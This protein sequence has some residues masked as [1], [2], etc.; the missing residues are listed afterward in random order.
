MHTIT[1]I[2]GAV[3]SVFCG[4]GRCWWGQMKERRGKT[5]AGR[6][7]RS[8][9][10]LGPR[11]PPSRATSAHLVRPLA[12]VEC[13]CVLALALCVHLGVLHAKP[14]ARDRDADGLPLQQCR[15]RRGRRD[16]VAGGGGGGG[17]GAGGSERRWR[18]AG[19]WWGGVGG[20]G[21]GGVGVWSGGAAGLRDAGAAVLPGQGRRRAQLA[22]PRPPFAPGA[23][24][25]PRRPRRVRRGGQG[26]R[27]RGGA[28]RQR[29]P[30]GR[31]AAPRCAAPSHP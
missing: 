11:P 3:S 18:G 9:R 17:G 7:T 15:R 19:W 24:A 26:A 25:T 4:R 30:A 10:C 23:G 12:A 22:A 6:R 20:W 29:S 5:P 1:V 28:G 13:V 27:R 31:G 14:L 2:A 16:H 21:W 8:A